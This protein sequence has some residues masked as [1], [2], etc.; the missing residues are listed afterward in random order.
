MF[1]LTTEQR[2][3]YDRIL[4]S[5]GNGK[6][7]IFFL[8]APG[9]TGKTF[10]IN[11]LLGKVRSE[12]K[13]ALGVATSGIAATLITGGRTAHSTFKLPLDLARN[14]T[15]TD[16]G[17]FLYQFGNF[18]PIQEFL[19]RFGNFCFHTDLGIFIPIWEFSYQF[20]NFYNWEFSY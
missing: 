12:G 16:L 1:K 11:L 17:I 13:I 18:L 9:G 19:Y 6:G 8:D 15:A 4:E 5:V 10:L 20:G 14:E 7:D 3:V 2:N